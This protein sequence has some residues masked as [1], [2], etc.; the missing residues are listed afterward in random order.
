MIWQDLVV[1]PDHDRVAVPDRDCGGRLAGARLLPLTKS[2]T[3]IGAPSWTNE[4]ASAVERRNVDR[5]GAVKDE[6]QPGLQIGSGSP[7][8][9]AAPTRSL[10]QTD[11]VGIKVR[12]NA[13]WALRD[14][15]ALAWTTVS[16]W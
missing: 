16:G 9:V 8:T 5:C 2:C 13:D 3:G 7:A 15:R 14:P 4:A 11:A 12:F 1:R 6:R 10:W